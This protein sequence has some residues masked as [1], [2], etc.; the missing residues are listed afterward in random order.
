MADSFLY[1]LRFSGDPLFAP[2]RDIADLIRF[3]REALVDDATM[4]IEPQDLSTGHLPPEELELFAG[5]LA[6]VAGALRPEGVTL[7]VNQWHTLMH[8]DLGQSLR[9]GQSFMPMVDAEG[10]AAQACLCPL[11]ENWQDYFCTCFARMAALGPRFLW[12]E[13]DFRYHNHAP[14]SWGGCFCNAHMALYSRKAGRELSRGEFIAGVLAP[15]EP[16]PYRQIWLDTCRE[17]LEAVAEKLGRAVRQADP[18]ARVGLMSSVPY[19]HCAEGRRWEPLLKKLACGRA[20]A[21]RV[22]LPAYAERVPAEYMRLFNM[23]SMQTRCFIPAEAEVYPELENYPY[24]L[25]SKSRA[26]TRFQMLAAMPLN[27]SGLLMNLFD[28]NGNGIV[29]GEGFAGMLREAKP[30]LRRLRESGAFGLPPQGV[31]VLCREDS[32]ATL[33]IVASAGAEGQSDGA[34]MPPA[35]APRGG[36]DGSLVADARDGASGSPAPARVGLWGSPPVAA[37]DC[38]AD[39]A[40]APR[41]GADGIAE[42]SRTCVGGAAEA[43]CIADG[44]AARE[45]A[46]AGR[47]LDDLCPREVLFAGLLPAFGIPFA[48]E[49]G[50]PP[51]GG[52][53]AVSGQALRN[54][55]AGEVRELFGG[56]FVLLDG[57]A[58]ETLI[59]MGLGALAGA[60][61]A[62]WM[63]QNTGEFTYEQ[64]AEWDGPQPR[65]ASACLLFCDALRVE[66][67]DGAKAEALSWFHNAKRERVCP[68]QTLVGGR[69]LIFPFGAFGGPADIPAMLLNPM[70][71][72][73]L[74]AALAAGTPAQGGFPQIHGAAGLIPYA[75]SRGAERFLYLVNASADPAESP[76]LRLPSGPDGGTAAAIASWADL[77]GAPLEPCGKGLWRLRLC[78]PPMEAVLLRWNALAY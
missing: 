4:F 67:E 62:R 35:A 41:M 25:F 72:D 48:Y 26:F 65:R 19:M 73:L 53:V 54:L 59:G 63:R 51:S 45:R 3:S 33:R 39:A 57:E 6:R 47:S 55:R 69:V 46:G 10:C 52:A 18:D 2:E 71:R 37:R 23:V 20:M 61:G 32:S 40:E 12:V 78:I 9:P 15:G 13:D 8:C 30:F 14:L 24:S 29:H 68:A 28:L 27:P 5:W 11:D 64:S 34:G 36:S 44:A 60:R 31:R 76:V 56:S 43:P 50:L 21:D 42:A 70:R 58:L 74:Q 75:Y 38:L 1:C 22:H 17:T 49:R 16:H 77:G 66:Y 7:S